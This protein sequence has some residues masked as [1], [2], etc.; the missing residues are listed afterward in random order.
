MNNKMNNQAK[1]DELAF[2]VTLK[3]LSAQ[4]LIDSRISNPNFP[5]GFNIDKALRT[6]NRMMDSEI[7]FLKKN[8]NHY[9]DFNC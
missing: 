2:L 8:P 9:L 6:L 3:Y 1:Q 7:Q 4:S 5:E